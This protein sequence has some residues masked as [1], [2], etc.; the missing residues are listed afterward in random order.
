MKVKSEY[1]K[2]ETVEQREYQIKIANSAIKENT[3]VVL[4]TGMGKT[5][6]ALLII[7][8]K[9]KEENNK[10]LFLAPTK[11]L[12]LQHAEFLR[13]FLTI[14]KDSAVVFTGE[15]SP[16]KRQN[17]WKNSRIIVSTPQVIE[18]DLLSKR[19]DLKEI[20]FIIFDECHHAVGEYAYVFVSEMYQKQREDGL[21]L[22]ITASPGN[23]IL[24]ILE[25]CKNLNISNIEIRTKFDLDVKPY[26]HDLKI[27]W[28]DI[29]L[30]KEFS[31]TIQLLK[32]ALSDRLQILKTI[33]VVESSSTSLINRTKLL[34]A[35]KKIQTEIRSRQKPPKIL[36]KAASIQSEAMKIHYALE[37]LQTQ[38][39]NALKNYFQRLGK[40]ASS[41]ESSKASRSIMADSNIL[42]A[43]AYVKS[44]DVEHPK[45]KEI[46]EIVKKQIEVNP[47]S[48]IIVFTHYRDTS[49]Y[50]SKLLENINKVKPSQFIGQAS[51]EGDKGLSQKEQAKVIE[52]FKNGTFNVLIA[53]SVAEE[54]LDIPSTDLVIFYEPIPS[55]IRAIQRRGRT[56][57]KMP[58]KVIILITKG[59]SD[60]AYYWASKRKEK[61]MRSELELIR[62]KLN[63]EF[64][65]TSKFYKIE[66]NGIT[67]QKTLR[68]YNEKKDQIKIIVDN[69]EYRSNVVRNLAIKET[70][71]EPQQLDVGDYVLS[72]RIGVERK[73]VED[74]LE[75]LIDGK[76]FKQMAQLRDAYSRPILILEGENLL[77]KRNINHNAIFG[78]LASISVD[79]GIP[80]LTTKDANETAD[81]LKVIAQREQRDD[82]KAVAVRGEKTQMSIRERQQF[83]IE[84]LPNV[85]AVLAKRLLKHFGSVKDIANATEEELL[86]VKGIGTNIASDI[87]KLLNA[88]YL[89]D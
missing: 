71:V 83:I 68:D 65:D 3:L 2:P 50:I 81:L 35:Q 31:Y 69:R 51:K 67:N 52:N 72:S 58:G 25:V 44:L 57:R 46:A 62:S 20:S 23:D 37:L 10:I 22:G 79:F 21:T 64:E 12:V 53:T 76:L 18:N 8:E 15:I 27:T 73:N 33:G 45:V 80:V 19:I 78:S 89:E 43:V 61:R 63:K 84:G 86:D 87:L 5:I 28:K 16:D 17:L 74:F 6:I 70:F 36:F 14:N 42:E 55:E 4:P 34:E 30:P 75:S 38:G 88:I 66:T 77:T 59:T 13:K 26:V 54:G 48:K 7:A 24:K 1:I 11:P 82:K 49:R 39:V 29:L 32:K 9:L 56:A 85:S 60:E 41:K 47:N 40:E